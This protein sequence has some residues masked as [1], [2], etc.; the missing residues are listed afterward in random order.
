MRRRAVSAYGVSRLIP[1]SMK[2]HRERSCTTVPR[3]STGGLAEKA[4]PCREKASKGIRQISPVRSQ[5]GVP[6]A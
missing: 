2:R 4:K 5:E 1:G 3:T 6:V